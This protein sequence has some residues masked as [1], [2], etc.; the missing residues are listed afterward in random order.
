MNLLKAR[1]VSAEIVKK[2]EGNQN[3]YKVQLPHIKSLGKVKT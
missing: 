2:K 3:I 1:I